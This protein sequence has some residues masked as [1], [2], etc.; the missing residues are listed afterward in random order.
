MC[1]LIVFY[2]TS[3]QLAVGLLVLLETPILAIQITEKIWCFC[4]VF[5]ISEAKMSELVARILNAI[6]ILWRTMQK[7]RTK[8]EPFVLSEN[9]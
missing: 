4:S 6:L 5:L 8:L 7:T 1:R 2:S 9:W 3:P